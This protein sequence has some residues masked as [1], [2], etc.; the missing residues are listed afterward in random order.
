M[1]VHHIP[2]YNLWTFIELYVAFTFLSEQHR[3]IVSAKK[4]LETEPG[5]ALNDKEIYLKIGEGDLSEN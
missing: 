4:I 5:E 1:V 2:S 3:S